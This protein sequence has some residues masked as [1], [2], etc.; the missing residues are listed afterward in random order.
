MVTILANFVY[1]LRAIY[2]Y[3]KAFYLHPSLYWTMSLKFSLGLVE[4]ALLCWDL[5]IEFNRPVHNLL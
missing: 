4:V 3:A 2:V 1:K 5:A